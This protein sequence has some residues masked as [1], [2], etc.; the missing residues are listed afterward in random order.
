[1]KYDHGGQAIVSI[2]PAPAVL[3]PWIGPA[4]LFRDVYLAGFASNRD[5]KT[6][7]RESRG[8]KRGLRAPL[9]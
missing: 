8:G 6:R 3:M 1:M 5:W 7:G 4:M 9:F 2:M